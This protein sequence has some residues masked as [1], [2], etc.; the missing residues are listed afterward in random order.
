MNEQSRRHF[1]QTSVIGLSAAAAIQRV[2]AADSEIRT[3]CR[4]PREVWIAAFG[5]HGMQNEDPAAMIGR[6]L[7]E[8]KKIAFHHPDIICLPET[9]PWTNYSGR[10]S[11]AELAEKPPGPITGQFAEFAQNHKCYVICPVYTT[12][13]DR[14]YNSAVVIDRN[15]RVMGE[16]QKIHPTEGEIDDGI[17]PGPLDPPVFR[18]D[19]GTIGVQICFD[20]N[21]QDG[22]EVLRKKGA[23]IIF[24]PSAF[25]GGQQVNTKAW[26]NKCCVVSSTNYGFSK[27][28]DI[29]AMEVAVTGHW[30]EH[31]AIGTVNLEK[32][33]L[34]TWP[35]VRR[36]TDIEKKYGRTI[37]I[38]NYHEEEWTILESLSPDVRVAD[39][40]AEFDIK[41][42]E[43]H[44]ASGERKQ[45]KSRP[46]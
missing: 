24:W 36:F 3:A 23:E 7:D 11:I 46:I 4:L 14:Y 17:T 35:Y 33:F 18:T 39:I 43:E 20:I 42:H 30:S 41:T 45:L 44:I 8:M 1:L 5:Q 6:T 12:H 25:G 37:R 15:G 27:I 29:D 13:G 40:L 28:C 38:K 34:H 9:F 10:H 16:Y 19:F 2:E 21:W 26:Q 32:V 22:W 31:W